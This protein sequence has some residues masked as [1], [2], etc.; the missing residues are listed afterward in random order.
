M[1][2]DDETPS[3]IKGLIRLPLIVIIALLM[4]MAYTSVSSGTF[5]LALVTGAVALILWAVWLLVEFIISVWHRRWKD[6]AKFIS[7][8][9]VVT[10]LVFISFQGMDYIKFIFIYPR[11]YPLF[12][13]TQSHF[14]KPVIILLDEYYNGFE[15][16]VY[17]PEG[18]R[19]AECIH[20]N[21]AKDREA[22][23]T[24]KTTPLFGHFY[25]QS[26]WW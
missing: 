2:K 16:L 23:F 15:Y 24:E 22:E 25:I 7:L 9:F 12:D 20:N 4:V 10:S 26:S 6:V 11:Y 5:I 14:H 1:Q 8:T 17:A 18:Q 13:I 3:N 19:Q 21:C